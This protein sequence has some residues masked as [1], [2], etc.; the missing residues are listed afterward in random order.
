MQGPI[1][2]LIAVD[3]EQKPKE[4]R[5]LTRCEIKQKWTLN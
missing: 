5:E 2:P 4:R 1:L 3:V